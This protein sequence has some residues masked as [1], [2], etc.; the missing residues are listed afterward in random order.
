ML[1]FCIAG[2]GPIINLIDSR[3]YKISRILDPQVVFELFSG[4]K[5]GFW[6]CPSRIGNQS[7]DYYLADWQLK[8]NEMKESRNRPVTFRLNYRENFRLASRSICVAIFCLFGSVIA[9]SVRAQDC[10]NNGILDS[11]E[12]LLQFEIRSEVKQQCCF[13][14]QCW[15]NFKFEGLP[16][17]GGDVTI[18]VHVLDQNL[19]QADEFI[20]VRLGS[21]EV[22]TVFDELTNGASSCLTAESSLVVSSAVW[23]SNL[24]PD[25]T[26]T[27]GL[28]ATE[29]VFCNCSPAENQIT[30]SYAGAADCDGDGIPND[31]E[32]EDCNQDGIPDSC[33]PD[34]D[35]DGVIDLCDRCDGADDFIDTDGDSVPDACDQCPNLNDN[36]D[37]NFNGVPD[38]T[39]LISP[40]S[41]NTHS[42]APP[43]VPCAGA[44]ITLEPFYLPA[45]S[46]DVTYS[47]TANSNGFDEA[48]QSFELFA[49]GIL[50]GSLFDGIVTANCPEFD[51][52]V[53]PEATW[54]AIQQAS[55][56]I[57][58]L[59]LRSGAN[60][61]CEFCP[62]PLVSQL[63][64]IANYDADGNGS[65]DSCAANCDLNAVDS[66]G[67]QVPDDCD[68]CAATI[69]NHPYVDEQGCPYIVAAAD[70][71]EDGDVD[72]ADVSGFFTC[73]TGP[74]IGA[75][76]G[77]EAFDID[78][79]TSID[80]L[81]YLQLQDA[82]SGTD[83]L[84][85]PEAMGHQLP[86]YILVDDYAGTTGQLASWED[87]NAHCE[88]YFGT[89]LATSDPTLS[90]AEQQAR[91]DEMTAMASTL[92]NIDVW[93]GLRWDVTTV[94]W[95]LAWRWVNGVDLDPVENDGPGV[96][97]W[98]DDELPLTGIAGDPFC[99]LLDS[100]DNY[101]W[102]NVSCDSLQGQAW[103]CDAPSVT[104]GTEQFY[105]PATLTAQLLSGGTNVVN[106]VSGQSIIFEVRGV[107]DNNYNEGLAG[108]TFDLAFDGGD[109]SPVT[110]PGGMQNFAAPIG[111]NNPA[112]FGGTVINGDLIQVGGGQNTMNLSNAGGPTGVVDTGIAHN[113]TVL[114]TGTLTAPMTPGTYTI[115]LSN[116]AGTVI[117]FGETGPTYRCE[118]LVSGMA[119]DLTI[120]VE[121]PVA[122]ALPV[123]WDD[124]AVN[125]VLSGTLCGFNVSIASVFG[126]A[127]ADFSGPEFSFAP[128]GSVEERVGYAAATNWTATFDPPIHDLLL[129]VS[130]WRGAGAGGPNP[131]IYDFDQSFTVVSGMNNTTVNGNI[132][133]VSSSVFER[134]I[135]YFPGPIS[136]LSVVTSATE[137]GAAQGLTFGRVADGTDSDGDGVEDACDLCPG[138]DP[139]FTVDA[140]GCTPGD[141]CDR[142]IDVNAG[143]TM[144]DLA[145]NTGFID[146]DNS[147]EVNDTIAE[148]L[149]FTAPVDGL[150]T[151]STCNPGTEFD[152][153]LSV[154]DGCP[155]NGGLEI[156]C[157]DDTD[158]APAECDL[159]GLNRKSTI[160]FSATS[161]TTYLIRVSVFNNLFDAQGGFGTA[162]E[163]SIDACVKGDLNGDMLVDVNDLPMFSAILVDPMI[164]TD[165]ELCTADVNEDGVVNGLDAQGFVDLVL[166]P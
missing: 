96:T 65:M 43:I 11:S 38:C 82:A 124:Q 161:G 16:A 152:T 137:T 144:G 103:L 1:R 69:P 2:R 39:E 41:V 12:T 75:G 18:T 150:V 91:I 51:A 104:F 76:L 128:L 114:A 126:S 138:T 106:A 132:L 158:G 86:N 58:E 23:D 21:Q 160:S 46:G 68:A 99:I 88:N 80:L 7:T 8:G 107:L 57:I 112:G 89:R 159:S 61:D 148:W 34:T 64:Y 115:S 108:F 127:T 97:N 31:C 30:V 87:A 81:D 166:A 116:L 52:L 133:E 29:D 79:S 163:L 35:G 72:D 5:D 145:D 155:S 121:E 77:C 109:L 143:L 78:G 60:T 131:V 66:D 153:T 95:E 118:P 102:L 14:V 74:D 85:E 140:D 53:I 50:L 33:F 92:G 83:V 25:G 56:G 24:N 20:F 45:A 17:T 84:A 135:L 27:I 94:P 164:A 49:N 28:K 125:G 147:C 156:A 110:V 4:C 111:Y 122:T 22:G 141:Q 90:P 154:Y 26:M 165:G 32:I 40:I 119:T 146:D 63:D 117:N 113:E 149:R 162:Y 71:D 62:A 9:E 47:I 44:S 120:I 100:Q 139:G 136:S 37:C 36:Q 13:A 73:E 98:F 19:G 67:D 151:I 6:W 55:N 15:R 54:N 123:D 59:E 157:N 48:D 3:A 142:P 101:E 129:Y 42:S 130:G 70:S 105:P 93:I 10:N 134:G